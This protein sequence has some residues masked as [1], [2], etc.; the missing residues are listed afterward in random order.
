VAA[1]RIVEAF[2]EREDCASG[3]GLCFEA[4]AI[5]QSRLP[6]RLSG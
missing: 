5:E 6:R 1:S 4:T 3:L 2:D